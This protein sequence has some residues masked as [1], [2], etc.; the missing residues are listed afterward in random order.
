MN[1]PG[2]MTLESMVQ[3]AGVE[4]GSGTTNTKPT[5]LSDKFSWPGRIAILIAVLLSPWAFGSVE[6]WAQKW[7]MI[8][9]LAGAGFWWFETALNKKKSQVFPTIFFL[10]AA[11]AMLGM[12]QTIPVPDGLSESVLGRQAK[13]YSELGGFADA[14]PTIS[15]DHEGTWHQVRLLMIALLGLA[16]GCRYFR[17]KRD[18]VL[19]MS[20]VATNGVLISFFGIIHKFTT[21]GKMYWVHEVILGGSPFGPFV[22]RNNAGGYLLMCLACCVGLL[23]I[24][25]AKRKSTESQKMI[26]SDIP[27]WQR[28]A[29]PFLEF[30]SELT[31]SKVALVFAIGIIGSAVVA[32]LSRGA[33]VAMISGGI[34]TLMVYGMA[35]RPKNIGL[36]LM[37]FLLLVV[38][39]SGWIGFWDE[40]GERFDRVD[41]ANVEETDDRI[42]HWKETWPAVSEMGLFGSGLGSYRGVHRLYRLENERTLFHYAENQYFQSL[43]EAGVVGLVLFLLAWMLA[44]KYTSLAVYR[45]NSET[46]IGVGTMGLFLIFSQAIASIFDFGFYITSNLLLM[47][48]MI[49]FLAYHGQSLAGRLKK[50]SWL[51][52]ELPNALVQFIVLL[53]FAGGTMVALDL[54][55][56]VALDQ[57]MQ[58]RVQTFDQRPMD[59]AEVEEK[60]AALMPLIQ[61]TPTVASLNYAGELWLYHS[62]LA[63]L[64]METSQPEYAALVA[65][66]SAEEKLATNDRLWSLLTVQQVHE[67]VMEMRRSG[68]PGDVRRFLNSN[69]VSDNYTRAASCFLYSSQRSPLQPLVRFRL[70]EI[71]GIVGDV[72]DGD[73]DIERALSLAPGNA[74]FQKSAGIYYLQSG[75]VELAADHF[76]KYIDLKPERYRRFMTELKSQYFRNRETVSDR[77]IVD[78]VIADHPKMIHDFAIKYLDKNSDLFRTSME[79]AFELLKEND[80]M[81][82]EEYELA[83]DVSRALGNGADAITK[84]GRALIR[85]PDSPNIRYKRAQILLEVGELDEAGKE[86]KYLN[87]HHPE[88]SAYN[89]LFRQVEALIQQEQDRR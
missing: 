20:V 88:N 9:L 51:R 38:A 80:T 61:R 57:L 82:F 22:N 18:I 85:K 60:I 56:R 4:S 65:P 67:Q 63:F 71:K 15:L 77:L 46:T 70:G 36:M 54:N 13:I 7:I 73:A 81:S 66:M 33:V 11:G 43:V 37:P 10:V 52:F 86:V 14:R 24:V 74:E 3:N 35:R 44:Y 32:T 42:Q 8:S 17:T 5:S 78:R 40:L 53:L 23:P 12:L 30:I 1:T 50:R 79:K 72:R 48:V 49:G 31:A 25:M 89:A 6:H 84:Y 19:L 87:A 45:G 59:T 69:P 58:P 83:G 39:L 16:L 27:L 26:S 29:L 62:R 21:N 76:R 47:S 55:R 2:N 75:N 34:G 28:M 64:E 41:V 68:N